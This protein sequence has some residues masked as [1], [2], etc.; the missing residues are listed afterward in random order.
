MSQQRA[1]DVIDDWPDDP[2]QVAKNVIDEYGP[3][4][5]STPSRLVW[6]DNG[7]WKRSVM[8]RD[9]TPHEF[10]MQHTDY[11]EQVIDYG[12]PPERYDDL[13]RFDGSVTVRRTRGELAAECHE[14][15]ANFLAL[16]LAHEILAGER[17]VDEARQ[18]YAES[19]AKKKAGGSPA[20]TEAFQFD[21]PEG[22][23]RDPDEAVLTD[24]LRQ[25]ARQQVQGVEGE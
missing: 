8:R 2:R 19:I 13:G 25:E 11:L 16:N 4:D 14:E 1:A 3:P 12:V 24:E 5:E 21:L 7:P 18:F 23:Q 22:D 15:A 17:S 10:P 6:F 9:G 20:Y